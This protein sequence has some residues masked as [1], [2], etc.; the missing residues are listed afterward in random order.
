MQNH[1]L[2]YLCGG[3]KKPKR[4]RT[5]PS[6]ALHDLLSG[7]HDVQGALAFPVPVARVTGYEPSSLMQLCSFSALFYVSLLF[8]GKQ[9]NTT[10]IYRP[11]RERVLDEIFMWVH[12]IDIVLDENNVQ[13]NFTGLNF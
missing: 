11:L 4:V 7:Q 10:S 8:S 9:N 12:A 13:E 5:G 6:Y 1:F 2:L 3:K